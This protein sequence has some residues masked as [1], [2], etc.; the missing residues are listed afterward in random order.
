MIDGICTLASWIGLILLG[1]VSL[2]MSGMYSGFETGLYVLNKIRL[3][4][5]AESG[6]KSAKRLKAM[7]ANYNKTLAV[8]LTGNNVA[9]YLLTFSISTLFVISG[10]NENVEWLAMAVATPLLFI[11]GESLPKMICQ[12][13]AEATTY[14]MVWFLRASSIFYHAIGLAGLVRGFAALFT[15]LVGGSAPLGHAEIA[16]LVAEGQA[17]GALTHS[18]SVMADRIMHLPGRLVLHAM[19]PMKAVIS[20]SATAGNEELL[21]L[22][23]R[24]NYSRIPL[25]EGERVV[26]ILDVHDILTDSG[27]SRASRRLAP[28]LVVQARLTITEALYLMQRRHAAMAVVA[29]EKGRHMGIITIKDLVEEIVGELEAW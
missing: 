18:Q 10:V 26:G 11:F 12:R 6:V 8:I 19:R 16:A 15:R 2:A 3:E 23:R 28:P 29:D 21:E 4:L 24:H 13:S 14:R 5:S 22:V 1:L 7:V 25:L 27:Q 17:S 9:N 20:A